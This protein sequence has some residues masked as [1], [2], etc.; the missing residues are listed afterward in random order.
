ME[1][2]NIVR[3]P[4]SEGK[5]LWDQGRYGEAISKFEKVMLRCD[6][7]HWFYPEFL[8]SFACLL[9]E[10]NRPDEAIEKFRLCEGEHLAR[11]EEESSNEV[12]LP[13]L[14][15]AETYIKKG[16][17]KKAIGLLEQFTEKG[18]KS[19][20]LLY[21]CLAFA[22]Y[23][24]GELLKARAAALNAIRVASEGRDTSK[25]EKRFEKILSSGG[26]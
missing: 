24:T 1:A 16:E 13:R 12:I 26:S 4:F 10:A 18:G 19:S 6:K 17:V 14:G 22:C 15:I 7:T 5:A 23:E 3:K 11:G 20:F 21:E 2:I 9:S 8:E 25:Y